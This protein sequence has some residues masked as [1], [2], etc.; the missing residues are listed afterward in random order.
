[1]PN[2]FI[3]EIGRVQ[4]FI[5]N[6]LCIVAHVVVKVD[7]NAAPFMEQFL[8]QHSGSLTILILS[9]FVLATL[10]VVVPQLLR[11]HRHKV[12]LMHAEQMRALE[13]GLPISRPDERSVFAGRT[14]LLVPMACVCTAGTVTCFLVAY[15]SEN[16]LSVTLGVWCVAGVVSLAAISGGIALLLRLAQLHTG[17]DEDDELAPYED[18]ASDTRAG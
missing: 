6:C 5:Q 9:A 3:P 4:Y 18:H 1:M 13:Q 17:E 8:Q 10:L 16:L 15:K 12:E 14:A 11:S 7:V 2:D